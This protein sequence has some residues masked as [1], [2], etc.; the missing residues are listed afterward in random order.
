M[1]VYPGGVR[2]LAGAIHAQD[3]ALS[4]E[5]VGTGEGEARV[6]SAAI[7]DPYILLH[8]TGYRQVVPCAPE[9]P[10]HQIVKDAPVVQATILVIERQQMTIRR[11]RFHAT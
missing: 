1:Q 4:S 5:K 2:L 11:V 3:V 7:M 9:T 10:C 8:L 6:L